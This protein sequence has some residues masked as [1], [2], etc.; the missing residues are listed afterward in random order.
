MT[1]NKL[2]IYTVYNL[3]SFDLYTCETTT[4]KVM[5]LTITPKISTHSFV[6]LL[7]AFV[8]HPRQPLICLPSLTVN[9]H[10]LQFYISGVIQ[11]ALFLAFTQLNY[12]EIQAIL[13]YIVHSLLLSYCIV[14]TAQYID[15]VPFV[16]SPIERH[17]C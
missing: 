9:L 11:Y 5:N 3:V 2:H 15:T 6:T 12:F 8:H 14:L 1:Y 4:I 16:H 13:L 17:L 10:F 7:V